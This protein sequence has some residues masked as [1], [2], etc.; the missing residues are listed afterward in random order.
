MQT[1]L[2]DACLSNA[3]MV[4]DCGGRGE[5]DPSLDV[6]LWILL[7]LGI[8][9]LIL[10]LAGHLEPSVVRPGNRVGHAQDCEP[11]RGDLLLAHG[12]IL[13]AE[14]VKLAAPWWHYISC[15]SC[16]GNSEGVEVYFIGSGM[17]SRV[18]ILWGT[19]V[20]MFLSIN[21]LVSKSLF[22]PVYQTEPRQ[23]VVHLVEVDSQLLDTPTL[24]WHQVLGRH[25]GP[26]E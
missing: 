6:H 16:T 21:W 13:S 7:Q 17:L 11:A 19:L 25:L 10:G 4:L 20:A 5:E 23:L 1:Y 2:L 3:L 12:H 9:I 8:H 18:A 24:L 15:S 14:K 22:L 26:S